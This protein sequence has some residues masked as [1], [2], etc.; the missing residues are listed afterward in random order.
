MSVLKC[1]AK[2]GFLQDEDRYSKYEEDLFPWGDVG[3]QKRVMAKSE[4][5]TRGL[6][7]LMST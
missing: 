3:G 2:A 1:T 7:I 5:T 6:L 4:I